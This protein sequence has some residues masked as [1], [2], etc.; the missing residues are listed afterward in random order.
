M[1]KPVCLS[2]E[3]EILINDYLEAI[4][5]YIEDITS[6]KEKYKN[7]LEISDI[8]I[9]HHNNYQSN[10][11]GQ[12]NYNDFLSIIPTHFTCMVNG[13]LTGLENKRNRKKVRLYRHVISEKAHELLED[14]AKLETIHE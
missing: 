5:L 2:I 10:N 1:L 4:D 6:T 8:I 11:L 13:Y 14:I 7:F 9:E 12:A 3:H